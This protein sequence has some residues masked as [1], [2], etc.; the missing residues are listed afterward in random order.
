[1]PALTILHGCRTLQLS[2]GLNALIDEADFEKVGRHK[3]NVRPRR[4]RDGFYVVRAIMVGTSQ[5]RHVFLHRI[6]MDA[7]EDVC[8]D[9]RNGD[10]RDN[11]RANLRLATF[12]QNAQNQRVALGESC[13]KGVARAANRWRARIRVDGKLI[14]LGCHATEEAAARAY[15]EAAR[16][17]F[18]EFACTNADLYG[19]Y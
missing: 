17:H 14:Q 8:V 1:M 15:D 5:Q 13:F 9:H 2:R 12:S 7:P 6:L 19:D 16:E 18:G 3:W 4:Q 10:S 11:R